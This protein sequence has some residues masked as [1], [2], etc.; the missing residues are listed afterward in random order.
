MLGRNPV[1]HAEIHEDGK[2]QVAEIFYTLQGEGP[3]AGHPAIFIRLTGCNLRC[4]FCDTQWDDDK[5]PY[6][7]VASIVRTVRQLSAPACKLVVLTGGE[8]MRQDLK[9]LLYGLTSDGAHKMTV[10]LETA[11]TLWQD[12]LFDYLQMGNLK[13]VVSP[14]TPKINDKIYRFAHAF[15]YVITEGQTSALDG[16]PIVSTQDKR[17]D[18]H[19]A[20]PR[21][22]ASVYLSPCDDVESPFQT[23]RNKQEVVQLAMKYGYIAGLQLHKIWDVR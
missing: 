5:D 7:T 10:Q 14:K 23:N 1:R 12:C 9:G 17:M 2:L 18:A 3:Y 19:I 6:I 15:K 20:R 11:G 13:I 21:P 22:G 8:P 4:Q 16:L